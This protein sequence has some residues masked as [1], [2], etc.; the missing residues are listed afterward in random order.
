M[1]KNNN[2]TSDEKGIFSIISDK[3]WSYHVPTELEKLNDHDKMRII[4]NRKRQNHEKV[5]KF[6]GSNLKIDVS[7]NMIQRFKLPAMIE[8]DLP[9]TYFICYLIKYQGVEN[10]VKNLEMISI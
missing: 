3:Q 7:L 1:K 8:S 10:L 6:F 5:R 2:L 9:L 4:R